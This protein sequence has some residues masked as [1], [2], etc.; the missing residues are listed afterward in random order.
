MMPFTSPSV[1]S[2]SPSILA[3]EIGNDNRVLAGVVALVVLAGG[4]RMLRH[5]ETDSMAI[6]VWVE[7]FAA[8]ARQSYRMHLVPC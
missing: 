5:S 7:G 3:P 2:R 8:S 6:V 1:V 4:N